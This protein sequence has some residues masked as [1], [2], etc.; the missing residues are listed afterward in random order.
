MRIGIISDIH[1]NF[2][3]LEVVLKALEY[4][5]ADT[6]ICLGDLVGYGPEPDLCTKKVYEACSDIILGN[7]DAAITGELDYSGFNSLA[8][9]ALEWT[10]KNLSDS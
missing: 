6:T 3:A 9:E 8:V 2:D 4:E 5:M 7:H 1:G 10:K